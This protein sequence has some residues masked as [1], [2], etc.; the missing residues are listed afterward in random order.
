V[1]TLPVRGHRLTCQNID[2]T[3]NPSGSHTKDAMLAVSSRKENE[4]P[5]L[6][7]LRPGLVG[8][9]ALSEFVKMQMVIACHYVHE[10]AFPSTA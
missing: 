7:A 9:G 8:S 4:L 1:P 6:P 10:A 5:P 3:E 2:R